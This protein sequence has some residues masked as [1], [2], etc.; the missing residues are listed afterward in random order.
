MGLPPDGEGEGHPFLAPLSKGEHGPSSKEGGLGAA[1]RR[2]P[3]QEGRGRRHEL[4]TL[5]CR[6]GW[7]TCL[8]PPLEEGSCLPSSS[9][10]ERV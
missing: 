6:R 5:L 9:P 2:S 8:P 3:L 10:P 7:I 1:P 4:G